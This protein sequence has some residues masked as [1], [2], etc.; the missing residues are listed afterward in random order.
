VARR[1]VRRPSDWPILFIAGFLCLLLPA[2]PLAALETKILSLESGEQP[3]RVF[4]EGSQAFMVNGKGSVFRIGLKDGELVLAAEGRRGEKEKRP[5]DILPDGVVLYGNRDIQAAWLTGATRRYDHGVL[6][7]DVEATG[8]AVRLAGGKRLDLKLDLGSVFE[9]RLARL[10]DLDGDGKDEIIA[11][12]SYLDEGAAL[13][14]A[15][16][17]P[18]GL[19]IIAETWPI[20]IPNRWLNPVGVGDFDGDGCNEVALVKTPHIGGSLE[21]YALEKDGL[22]LKGRIRGFSNHTIDDR[23]LGKAAVI[24]IDGDGVPEIIL[25][26]S[27]QRTLRIISFKGGRFSE[28]PPIVH[29]G[30]TIGTA[31]AATDL[32]GDGDKEIVYGLSDGRMIAV[33]FSP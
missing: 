3:V 29:Q 16:P 13:A 22:R 10:A 33:F 25:P 19:R 26:D 24:D 2:S 11:V 32:D 20:G 1:T 23:E 31:L 28:F 8:I 18:K 4:T 27:W 14:V 9:D 15:K 7:D 12:R 21:I 30:S 17:G 5:K 6:G